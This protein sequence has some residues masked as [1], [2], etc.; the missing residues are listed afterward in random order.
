MLLFRL[1]DINRL[2]NLLSPFF[3]L[4]SQAVPRDMSHVSRD[5]MPNRETRDEPHVLRAT[6]WFPLPFLTCHAV[7]AE[8]LLTDGPNGITFLY[9]FRNPSVS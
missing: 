9:L 1:Q 8:K 5:L 7:S 2:S 3:T 4:P 6:A